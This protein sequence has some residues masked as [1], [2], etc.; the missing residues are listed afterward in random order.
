MTDKK[1]KQNGQEFRLED[2]WD[3]LQDVKTV[4]LKVTLFGPPVVDFHLHEASIVELTISDP[5]YDS[6]SLWLQVFSKK[7]QL[8]RSKTIGR[9]FA[10]AYL[11]LTNETIR[12]NRV[13]AYTVDDQDLITAA[14]SARSF[15]EARVSS[16]LL[17]AGLYPVLVSLIHAY[18]HAS[19]G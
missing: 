5:P 8:S 15:R 12:R 7:Y 9:C 10:S 18:A 13:I 4:N 1:R 16:A 17:P 3:L 2:H 14:E 11:G 19:L 6:A